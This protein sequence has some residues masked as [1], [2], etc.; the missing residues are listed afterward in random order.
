MKAFKY[1]AITKGGKE[2]SGVIEAYDEYEAIAQIKKDCDII[3]KI[4]AVPERKREGID[5]NEPTSIADNIL[6]LTAS[7]FAILLRTGLPIERTVGTVT[8]QCTD[9]YMKKVLG[10]VYKDVQAGYPLSKSLEAHGKKIPPTFIETIKAGELSASLPASFDKLAEYYDKRGKLK[11][12]IKG[13]LTYPAFLI[14][15]MILVVIIVVN[16]AVPT[17]LSMFGDPS[18]VP[19]VTKFLLNLYEFNKQWWW[20]M[21]IIIALLIAAYILYGKTENGKMTLAKLA[22]KLPV[23]GKINTM[24]AASQFASTMATLLTSGLSL[25]N[26]L[27]TTSKV[28]DNHAVGTRVGKYA[29]GVEEGKMLASL[30]ADDPYLP[31][32]LVEMTAVGEESGSLEDTLTTIAAYFDSEA[33]LATNKAVSMIEP[34]MTIVLGIVIGFVVI[35]LYLP[36]FTMYNYM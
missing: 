13:A 3:T 22:L 7:Q 10:G 33:T 8:Q 15:L 36:M 29:V 5:L 4:D 35:A 30:M 26:S 11:A 14:V 28:I 31:P 18:Q 23:V 1:K 21:I 2:V 27:G 20:L 6:S 12:K 24:N 32:L 19:G 16:F 9:K 17:V 34:I 25:R